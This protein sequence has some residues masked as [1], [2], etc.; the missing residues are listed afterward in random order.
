MKIIDPSDIFAIDNIKWR[1]SKYEIGNSKN[2]IVVIKNFFKNPDI[3]T[4]YAKSLDYVNTIDGQISGVPGYVHRIGNGI[5]PLLRPLVSIATREFEAHEDF[6][7][8]NPHKFTF[9]IYPVGKEVNESSLFPHV[10][11]V[12]YAGVCSLNKENEYDGN[13]NGT[14][15]WINDKSKEEYVCKDYN[16]RIKRYQTKN[17]NKVNLDPCNIDIPEWSI[18]HI[19]PHS[20]N[21]LV[22]YEGNLWHSPYFNSSSW[23]TDRT[24]FNCFL[25]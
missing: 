14:A 24:T 11:N 5:K 7:L 2:R 16:Y 4:E 17:K 19:I 18:Y 21:T 3:L 15:L 9:Q 10:D 6:V 13:D 8:Q 12:R 22:L 25:D 23:K 1:I 20:Y